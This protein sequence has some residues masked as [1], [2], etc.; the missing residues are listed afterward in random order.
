MATRFRKSKSIAP[1]VRVNVSKGSVGASFGGKGARVS[2]NSKGRVTRSVGIPGSGLYDVEVTNLNKSN[3][4]SSTDS[5]NY[6]ADELVSGQGGYTYQT[7]NK[8]K[9]KKRFVVFI[10]LAVLFIAG[11]FSGI[12]DNNTIGAV[13]CLIL[14]IVFAVLSVKDYMKNK[15]ETTV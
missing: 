8:G 15:K 6:D 14:G 7:A 2:V 12:A 9:G 5:A 3:D 4:T 1:G 13:G 11:F 10:V